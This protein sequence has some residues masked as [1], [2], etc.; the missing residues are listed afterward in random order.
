[1][2]DRTKLYCDNLS[3]LIKIETISESGQ[4][5]FTK[6]YHFHDVLRETF[7]NIF[8]VCEFEN[9]DGSFLMKWEGKDPS[10][11]PILLM[12][13]HD[14]VEATGKWDHDPFGGEVIDGK[15]WGRGTLDT[16]G[17]LWG[18]FQ[19]ADE[20]AKAGFVPS[21]DVYF[22]SACTEEI[23]GTGCDT[24]TNV[25]KERGIKFEMT[26]DEGGM[27]ISEPMPGAKGNYA[28]IGIGEKGCADLKFI[29]RSNG[30]HASMPGKNTPLVRLGKFMAEAEKAKV[31]KCKLNKETQEMFIRLAP[32]IDGPLKII[33]GHPKFFKPLIE[34]VMPAVSGTA[35]A[36][37]RTTI[38]FTTAKGSDGLN[39]LPQAAYVTGNM[40]FSHHQGGEASIKAIS[41]LA[42]KYDIETEIIDPGF[43]SPLSSYDSD[44][45]KLVEKAVAE[46]FPDVV[47]AP[48]IMTGASDSRYMGR[49][50]DNCIR[51]APFI[52]TD[53]QLAGI[54]GLNENIDISCLTQ[55][56]DFYK[57]IIKN[58]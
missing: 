14:V 7:P 22:E 17:G 6:F 8:A 38:A 31:F 24:I 4:T 11:L 30:G 10:K 16:K 32:H 51:F 43:Q 13:H 26:L 36:L 21:R 19:A 29:A 27:I 23:E 41:D 2:D 53:E 35:A 44:A 42:K 49:V 48:Y 5:D 3:K 18:M 37:L 40:R 20:L 25:L 46:I 9:F 55:A 12:N 39:V 54:H 45:F 56:V 34:K 57:Y 52:V 15:L 58:A 47:S 28:M 33:L 50:C 1:M